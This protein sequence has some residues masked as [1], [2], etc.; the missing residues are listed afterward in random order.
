MKNPI[1]I[2]L[3]DNVLSLVIHVGSEGSDISKNNHV[4]RV[5]TLDVS[6][7][8]HLRKKFILFLHFFLKGREG[9]GGDNR[10]CVNLVPFIDFKCT[11]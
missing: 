6:D 9:G 3:H 1:I 7:L 4:N 11:P 10:L 5:S 8:I 2:N